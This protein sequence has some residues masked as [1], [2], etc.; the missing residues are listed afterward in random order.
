[1]GSN[2]G[3]AKASKNPGRL[4]DWGSLF[5]KG[6]LQK[7]RP[8]KLNGHKVIKING[9]ILEALIMNHYNSRSKDAD[10]R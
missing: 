4:Q 2:R 9:T 8:K 10:G 3:A 1:M 5:V 6:R 7:Q